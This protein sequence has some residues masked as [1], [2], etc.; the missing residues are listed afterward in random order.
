MA[1]YFLV[2][3]RTVF[4]Q[5]L[6]PALAAAWRQR[7]FAPCLALCRQWAPAARDYAARYHVPAED[8]LLLHAAEGLPF[9]RAFW[10]SLVGEFLLFA[11]RDIPEFPTR[12]DTLGYLLAGAPA[13]RPALPRQSLPA[14]HQALLGSRDLAFGA[15]LY[16]PEQA[17]Y[18]NAADVARLA[19]YLA[20][21]RPDAWSSDLLAAVPGLD[22]QD[23]AEELAFAREWFAALSGLYTRAADAGQVIVL[24]SIF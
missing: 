23:R 1:D 7:S 2:H 9:D 6:R 15:A 5:H 16:R 11:A 3:D 12:L 13:D 17:G 14:I 22:E 4:E 21:V 8:V 10:R 24:E 20:A 19:G 18:N